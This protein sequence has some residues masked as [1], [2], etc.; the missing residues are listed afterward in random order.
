[1]FTTGRFKVWCSAI[2]FDIVGEYVSEQIRKVACIPET[3]SFQSYS[4]EMREGIPAHTITILANI[5]GSTRTYARSKNLL[6]T[7]TFVHLTSIL[8]SRSH[9]HESHN[10]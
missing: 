1:M 9:V 10:M 2:L 5:L 8:M 4:N 6:H 3:A 7:A